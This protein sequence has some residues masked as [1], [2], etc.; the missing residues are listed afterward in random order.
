[1]FFVRGFYD[2]GQN[3]PNISSKSNGISD[4]FE[5]TF[6]KYFLTVNG[7]KPTIRDPGNFRELTL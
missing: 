4:E 1:M 7:V 5:S 3:G 2:D 6:I